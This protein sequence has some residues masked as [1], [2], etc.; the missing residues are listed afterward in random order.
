MIWHIGLLNLGLVSNLLP[1]SYIMRMV[2][3][4]LASH[5]E[6]LSVSVIRGRFIGVKRS[7][8]VSPQKTIDSRFPL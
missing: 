4:G 1:F 7:E 5:A 8:V 2:Y 3:Y 6:F